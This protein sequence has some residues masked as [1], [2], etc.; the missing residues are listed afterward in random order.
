MRV[1]VITA[2]I[3]HGESHKNTEKVLYISQKY[4]P[5]QRVIW[6]AKIESSIDRGLYIIFAI[7]EQVFQL[8]FKTK[9]FG[10]KRKTPFVYTFKVL[11]NTCSG[12][13][14]IWSAF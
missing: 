5:E 4:S 6:P 12:N 1:F 7:L 11:K 13:F 14:G 10:L 8:Y 9:I 3:D 2:Q